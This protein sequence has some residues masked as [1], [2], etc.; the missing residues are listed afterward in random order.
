MKKLEEI[1]VLFFNSFNAWLIKK[2]ECLHFIT[3]KNS[4]L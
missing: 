1:I 2:I 3:E 4:I